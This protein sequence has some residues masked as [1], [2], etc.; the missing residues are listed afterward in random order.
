VGSEKQAPCS[1]AEPWGFIREET[2][3]RKYETIF[4]LKPDMA[5][6]AIEALYGRLKT[7]LEARGGIIIKVD[8]WGRKKLAYEIRKHTK[9]VYIYMLYA[10]QAEGVFELERLLRMLQDEVLKYMTV[11]LEEIDSPADLV[12]ESN[13]YVRRVTREAPRRKKEDRVLS[14]FEGEGGDDDEDGGHFRHKRHDRDDDD[15]D[16]DI[17]DDA[18]EDEDEKEA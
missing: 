18:D 7:E 17:L 16:E 11:N 5:E 2:S 13:Q 14:G 8:N 3:M 9:G 6:E 15:D 10:S 4:I 12:V 1:R